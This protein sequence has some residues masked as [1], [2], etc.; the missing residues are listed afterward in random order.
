MN[1]MVCWPRLPAM[2]LFVF[3]GHRVPNWGRSSKIFRLYLIRVYLDYCFQ[4]L[5]FLLSVAVQGCSLFLSPPLL[6]Q[7][8][9]RCK[10]DYF[11]ENILESQS[12]FLVSF[13]D[14]ISQG[15]FCKCVYVIN[16]HLKALV[17]V[18]NTFLPVR[19]K[20]RAPPTHVH[21]KEKAHH[22]CL[23]NQ[24]PSTHVWTMGPLNAVGNFSL[25]PSPSLNIGLIVIFVLPSS[26]EPAH[27]SVC[28]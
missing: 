9:K 7:S 6:S 26:S 28:S 17:K 18:E 12:E 19:L 4:P 11:C 23:R 16:T 14:G 2:I 5:L 21:L 27:F 10:V 15:L 1:P 3:W 8:F 13:S 25:P 24:A 20:L 22:R